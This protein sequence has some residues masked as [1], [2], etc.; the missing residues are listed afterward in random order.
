MKSTLFPRIA[1]I[2]VGSIT[3]IPVG[4]FFTPTRL[5]SQRYK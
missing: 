3:D 4:L 1:D 5:E 2:L